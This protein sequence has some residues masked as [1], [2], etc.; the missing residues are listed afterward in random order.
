MTRDLSPHLNSSH[1]A[2]LRSNRMASD[3][4]PSCPKCETQDGQ[5]LWMYLL[6]TD[7]EWEDA[8][9]RGA[10][11][12]YTDGKATVMAQCC[13]CHRVEHFDVVEARCDTIQ[14][15][16]SSHSQARHIATHTSLHHLRDAG[17]TYNIILGGK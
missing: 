12:S 11:G 14:R 2:E 10:N 16:R 13:G 1:F 4:G 7:Q 9:T 6:P 17:G 15:V 5:G 3:I 8:A